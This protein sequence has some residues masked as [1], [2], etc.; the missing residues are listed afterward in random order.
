M[1]E[2]KFLLKYNYYFI[3]DDKTYIKIKEYEG[4]W[5]YNLLIQLF[6][7]KNKYI[8]YIVLII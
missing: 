7:K 3:D 1:T 6:E 5:L 4:K 8:I 2:L